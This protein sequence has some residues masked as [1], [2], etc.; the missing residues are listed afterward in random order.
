MEI[1]EEAGEDGVQEPRKKH[2]SVMRS[3]GGMSK[4]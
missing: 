4:R 3:V 1:R 2:W